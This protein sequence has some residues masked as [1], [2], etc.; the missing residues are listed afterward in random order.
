MHLSSRRSHRSQIDHHGPVSTC[1]GGRRAATRYATSREIVRVKGDNDFDWNDLAPFCPNG[2]AKDFDAI[3]FA[4]EM[5]GRTA[6]AYTLVC[7]W[8]SRAET[9]IAR[10]NQHGAIPV[11][12]WA[13]E[14]VE[15][16]MGWL[17]D[18]GLIPGAGRGISYATPYMRVRFTKRFVSMEGC[19]HPSSAIMGGSRTT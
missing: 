14:I 17:V 19:V 10:E 6:L 7:A 9:L 12:L 11:V 3:W 5:K 1:K 16:A 13:G 4:K 18:M 15:D 8:W 2:F